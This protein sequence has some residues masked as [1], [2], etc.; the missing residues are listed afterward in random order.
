MPGLTPTK[1]GVNQDSIYTPLF[2]KVSRQI[3]RDESCL[4]AGLQETGSCMGHLSDAGK[5]A[6]GV[7]NMHECSDEEWKLH[8]RCIK[9][10]KEEKLC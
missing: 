8:E 7:A 6:R 5:L 9:M 2:P 10:Y 1:S 4:P 3:R